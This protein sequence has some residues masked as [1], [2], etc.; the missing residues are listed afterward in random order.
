M[1]IE[2]A[3]KSKETRVKQASMLNTHRSLFGPK[4]T[5]IQKHSQ[6]SSAPDLWRNYCFFS[7]VY[8][9]SIESKL[10]SKAHFEVGRDF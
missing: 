5:S 8:T 2:I 10:T 7:L 4:L 1:G 6:Y 3:E 9:I